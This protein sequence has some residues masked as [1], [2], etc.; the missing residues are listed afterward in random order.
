MIEEIEA[1]SF[2]IFCCILIFLSCFKVIRQKNKQKKSTQK[3]QNTYQNIYYDNFNQETYKPLQQKIV[4]DY[5]KEYR[6]KIDGLKIKF[7][8]LLGKEEI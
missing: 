4:K 8:N 7:N 5:Y 1:F 2:L 6:K 3:Q